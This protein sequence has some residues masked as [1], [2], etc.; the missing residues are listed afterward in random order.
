M[1]LERELKIEV[2]IE[3]EIELK[4]ELE[5]FGFV[6]IDG[7][8]TEDRTED[9]CLCQN[10][11]RSNWRDVWLGQ[12]RPRRRPVDPG[13]NRMAGVLK[14]DYVPRERLPAAA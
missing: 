7:D 8:E 1:E 2:E 12:N 11:R 5:M 4:I 9:V 14:R 13:E 3:V 10:Q 6:E